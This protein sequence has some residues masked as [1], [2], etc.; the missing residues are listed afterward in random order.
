M[1]RNQPEIGGKLKLKTI[2]YT[3]DIPQ[4]PSSATVREQSS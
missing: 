4:R 3:T 2:K 1:R